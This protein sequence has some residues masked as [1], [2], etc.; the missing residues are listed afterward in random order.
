MT[1]LSTTLTTNLTALERCA[2]PVYDWLQAHAAQFD[3]QHIVSGAACVADWKMPDGQLLFGELPPSIFYGNWWATPEGKP[4]AFFVIGMNLGY[5]VN[6]LLNA[7]R[8][9]ATVLV[10]E[11]D[12]VMLLAALSLTDYSSQLQAKRLHVLVPSADHIRNTLQGLDLYFLFGETALRLDTPSTQ[13]GPEYAQWHTLVRELLDDNALELRTMRQFQDTFVRNELRNLSRTRRDGSAR[14]LNSAGQGTGG[15]ILGAGPSLERH[16][17]ELARLSPT[18]LTA[19]AFQTLPALHRIGLRP[20]FCMLIDPSPQLSSVFSSVG[21]EYLANLPL[22]YS[23]KIDPD[24]LKRYPGPTTPLWTQ[25]GLGSMLLDRTEPIL[26]TG[27]NVGVAIFRLLTWMKIGHVVLV[28]QDFGWSGER[29]HAAGHNA[30][31]QIVSAKAA[32]ARTVRRRDGRII[33]TSVQLLQARANL[34]RDIAGSELPVFT[35]DGDGLDLIGATTASLHELHARHL[36]HADSQATQNALTT[37]TTPGPQLTTP[38]PGSC[39]SELHPSIGNVRR[40]LDHL[41]QSAQDTH[42]EIRTTLGQVEFFLRAATPYMPF[43]FNEITEIAWLA[44]IKESYDKNDY[45]TVSAVLTRVAAKITEMDQFL[46]SADT[47][48]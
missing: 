36:L 37:L 7:A 5:G 23:P 13:R 47:T 24:L 2:K 18:L 20:H 28:G 10:L 39:G 19:S 35:V 15:L 11:P 21:Q 25:G 33:Q 38:V 17:P 45:Q 30:A 46:T 27:N 29:S 32:Y 26:N 31:T 44:R 1:T 40:R 12:P 41:F 14:K 9:N 4:A 6:H 3:P 42:A 48:C 43:L 8:P 22:I 16:G 34:E